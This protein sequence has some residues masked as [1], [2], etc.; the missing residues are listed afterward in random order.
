MSNKINNN[1]SSKDE[2]PP[3]SIHFNKLVLKKYL[4]INNL[5]LSL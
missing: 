4:C 1:M 5:F 2:L 3:N